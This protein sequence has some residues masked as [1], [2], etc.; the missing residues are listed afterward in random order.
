MK[1]I[2]HPHVDIQSLDNLWFQVSGTVCN[3]SC[4]HCFNSSSPTN[5]NFGLLTLETC[6]RYLDE[7][8]RYG[9]KEYYF[10]GG[11][12]FINPEILPILQHT[13]AYGPATVLTNGVLVTKDIAS[14]LRSIATS[15]IYSLEI[16]VSLDG[17]TSETNDA[18]RGDGV[19]ERA[20][21]GVRNLCEH[22]FLPIITATRTWPQ[23][24]D[25]EMM[26]RFKKLL[27]EHGYI[28]PRIKLLPSLKIGKEA[29]RTKGYDKSEYVSQEMFE[30]Y[31]A[32][33]LL[34][35]NSRLVTDKGVYVCPILIE[36]EDACMGMSITDTMRPFTLSHQA[37]YS[38]YVYGAICYNFSTK[39]RD[40]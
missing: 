16:R 22:G 19:F 6:R 3:L 36:T 33:Q 20:L 2:D 12:P 29:V 32:T 14:S 11:E 9:V 27:I 37:C 30:D 21:S 35:S 26:K 18:I 40:L 38:C 31:D 34:C 28:R 24:E 10:T 8:V 1:I 5:R 13:L 7:S 23:T 39:A 15:T 4:K 17:V 25:L